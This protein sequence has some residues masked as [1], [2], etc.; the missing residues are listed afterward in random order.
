MDTAQKP[1]KGG[2]REDDPQKAVAVTAYTTI[3]L[4]LVD[5]RGNQYFEIVDVD[6][7]LQVTLLSRSGRNTY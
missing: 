5:F 2:L 6:L 4:T 7:C 3:F 1:I